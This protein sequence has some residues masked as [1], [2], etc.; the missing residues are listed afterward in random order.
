MADASQGDA[1]SAAA[2][3]AG[4]SPFGECLPDVDP[5]LVPPLGM[6]SRMVTL[7]VVGA[8]SKF[9]VSGMNRATCSNYDTLLHHMTERER[10]QGLITVSNHSSTFD[11]PGVLSYL[12]PWW[13]FATEPRHE[14]VRWTMCTKE[15]CAASPAVHKFFAA[16]KTVPVNRGGGL[17]QRSL[18]VMSDRL[19]RG[20]WL[21]LFPEGRVSK[22]A[23]ELGRLK[24]G[25]G[26]MVCDVVASGGPRPT[27]LPFWHS[28]MER[29]KK[30]G[31]WGFSPLNHVHVTVGEPVELAD[32][33]AR[34]GRCDTERKREELYAAM[35]A[36]VEAAMRAT[37]EKNLAERDGTRDEAR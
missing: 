13:Y 18:L 23:N 1:S 6:F 3:V 35:A 14:G 21:H 19:A 22:N 2:A 30:Y 16:G 32:L 37:R 34:C 17:N 33:A 11:D 26:K 15:I 5:P 27:V 7:G 12:I 29:V 25:L 4:P 8:F 9:V 10:P 24:W 28:G 20:D 36:R 31:R